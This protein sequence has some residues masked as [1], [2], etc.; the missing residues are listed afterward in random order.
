MDGSK[1]HNFRFDRWI[2]MKLLLEFPDALLHG[3][4][5]ESILDDDEVWSS[6]AGWTVERP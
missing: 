3:V 1:G 6:Q 4:D 5:E 2:G